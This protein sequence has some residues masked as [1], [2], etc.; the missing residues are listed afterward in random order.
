MGIWGDKL[1]QND[2]ALDV[3]NQFEEGIS[4]GKDTAEITRQLIHDFSP[5]MD[6]PLEEVLFWL[7][8][9]DAQWNWGRLLPYVKEQAL[10]FMDDF[11]AKDPLTAEQQ[12][13]LDHLRSKILSPQPPIKKPVKKEYTDANGKKEMFSLSE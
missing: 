13:E 8:L 12:R 6:D 2:T 11:Q 5:L 10:S 9:A 7:A 3:K 1:Y 4:S